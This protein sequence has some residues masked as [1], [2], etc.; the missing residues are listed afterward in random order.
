MQN[1]YNSPF[2]SARPLYTILSMCISGL[3]LVLF[4]FSC[5][6]IPL[7]K[8]ALYLEE[9]NALPLS[10]SMIFII[11][12]DGDYVY[13]D[14]QGNERRADEMALIGATKVA[15]LNP[16]AEVFIFHEKPRKQALLFIPIPDGKFYYF[17]HGQLLA[18]E[19]YW[20]NQGS[21]RFDPEVELYHRFYTG[22]QSQSMRL[23]L[24]FGHEIPEFEGAGYDESYSDW[25]FTIHHFA[26]GLKRFTPDS[27]KVDLLVL[28][29]CFNGTPY[30]I[31]ALAPYAR[32][33]VASPDNLH[34]SYF[35]LQSFERLDIGL[36]GG[37]VAAFSKKFAQQAF[38]GLTKDIQT[39]VTVA[40][41]DVHGVQGF[42]NNVDSVY[43]HALATLKGLPAGSIEH[44]DCAED[45]TYVLPGM[46]EGVDI[47]YRPPQFGRSKHIQEHSGWECWRLVN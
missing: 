10:Y 41:Y 38:D 44:C 7:T 6:S 35:D 39:A 24:Y 28:S 30:S 36:R 14:T 15:M 1:R 2:T 23:F 4:L 29:T 22:D 11:H 21:A 25:T 20:R 9:Q 33:I 32:T 8:Q 42:L 12:G 40:V 34:L 47:F 16:Q 46:N 13:H 18:K 31:S 26:E 17:R 5:S 19:S 43:D 37:D 45:S 3:V 27:S